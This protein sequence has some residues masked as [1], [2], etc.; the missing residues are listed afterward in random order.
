MVNVIAPGGIEQIVKEAAAVAAESG[1]PPD[2]EV[3]A[4]IASKYD[5]VAV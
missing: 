5:F 1:G 4:R 3:M 2:P